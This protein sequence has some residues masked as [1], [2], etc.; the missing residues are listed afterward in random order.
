M[1]APLSVVSV[2]ARK[3][4]RNPPIAR[5]ATMSTSDDDAPRRPASPRKW[6]QKGLTPAVSPPPEQA[7]AP[8]P[9]RWTVLKLLNWTTD[10]LRKKGSESPRLDAEVLLAHVLG[11]QRVALYTHFA[12][13]PAEPKRS[14]F[15]ELVKRRADGTPVAYLVGRKEFFSLPLAVTPAVL[16][17]RPDTETL[18]V[19][20]LNRLKQMPAPRVADIGTGSGAIAL[21]CLN[22]HP[23]AIAFATDISPDALA[24]ARQNAESLAL[25]DR[26]TLRQGDLLTPIAADG[27]F[28]AI[29]SNPPYI[30]T[31]TISLLEPGVRDHEPHLA[32]DG[33]PDGLEVVSRLIDQALPLL[34]PGG[35]L[36]IEIGSDQ[37]NPVRDRLQARPELDLAPTIRDAANHPRVLRATR[38]GSEP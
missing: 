34:K 23:G 8:S 20:F 22:E 11:W 6:P 32:L 29:L 27:P 19:E 12:D 10:F 24:I 36:I 18:V 26:L 33:G 25:L 16:I 14:A 3:S 28:D 37:E 5:R 17:P 7:D 35:F 38:R 4:R 9:D 21:A 13:E 30:P 2:Q 1:D 15:R 31:Q